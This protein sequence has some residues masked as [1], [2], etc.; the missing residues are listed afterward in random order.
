MAFTNIFSKKDFAQGKDSSLVQPSEYRIKVFCQACRVNVNDVTN[1]V[2]W[3]NM[4]IDGEISKPLCAGGGA[5][6]YIGRGHHTSKYIMNGNN[7]VTVFPAIY[8]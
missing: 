1:K 7:E 5:Q 8:K 4:N 6:V 2:N 3:F